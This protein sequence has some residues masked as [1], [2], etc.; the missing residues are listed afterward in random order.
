MR[1]LA[2]GVPNEL[3]AALGALGDVVRVRP[4][5][6]SAEAGRGGYD[7]AV[8]YVEGPG[9]AEVASRASSAGVPVVGVLPSG[10]PGLVRLLVR[11]GVRDV[12]FA[13]TADQVVEAVRAASAA[14]IARSSRGEGGIVAVIGSQGGVGRSTVALNLSLL[15]SERG[16]VVLVDL[17]PFFGVL[18]VLAD[19]EPAVTVADVLGGRGGR[20]VEVAS[21][22][23]PYEGI[24]ILASPP[25]PDGF[26]P[27]PGEVDDLLGVLAGVADFVVV[28][29]ERALLPYTAAVLERAHLV[30]CLARLTVP[31]L[32]NVKA[33]L[34]SF[35]HQHVPVQ[36]VVV[37]G[38][39]VPGGVDARSADEVAGIEVAHVLPWDATSFRAE[40]AGVPVV[41][42][43]PGSKLGRSLV[44]LADLV[45]ER[46]RAPEGAEA[47]VR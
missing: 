41:V 9:D 14:P 18:H 34:Q 27:D 8:V 36:K 2:V 3:S 23:V 44:R 24:R 12:L 32:R 11:S 6:L 22:L 7:A 13:P 33:Y 4:E 31:G 29:V 1:V 47:V 19:L 25:S 30:L 17:V 37:V 15:L 16:S 20:G 39:A 42:G 35:L 21:A 43:A 28:D 45:S 38:V 5:E 40:N 46:L 10:D 26:R